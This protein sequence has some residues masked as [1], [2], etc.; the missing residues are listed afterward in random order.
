MSPM[1]I[2]G[3]HAKPSLRVTSS[4]DNASE[5]KEHPAMGSDN[6]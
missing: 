3:E 4:E 6:V 2:M 5:P 1:A